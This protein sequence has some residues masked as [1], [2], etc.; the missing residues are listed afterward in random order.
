MKASDLT[1]TFNLS[2]FVW[3]VFK[4]YICVIVSLAKRSQYNLSHSVMVIHIDILVV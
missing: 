3:L 4:L 1:K 2:V